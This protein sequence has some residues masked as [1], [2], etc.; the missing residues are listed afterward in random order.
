MFG[1]SALSSGDTA[2]SILTRPADYLLSSRL[3][4]TVSA[5]YSRA[6]QPDPVVTSQWNEYSRTSESNGPYS[7]G[8]DLY[9][10][11]AMDG[12]TSSASAQAGWSTTVNVNQSTTSEGS[13]LTL[14]EQVVNTAEEGV[15][16]VA[17]LL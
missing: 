16:T 1:V 10:E 3:I 6:R 5:G 4:D 13:G 9:V 7:T 11:I 8:A 2:L 15:D 17:G 12:S 14:I